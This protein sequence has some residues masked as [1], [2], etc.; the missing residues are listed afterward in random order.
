M[1]AASGG[2]SILDLCFVASHIYP[3]ASV[4]LGEDL[5]SDHSPIVVHLL[6]RP[7][8]QLFKI[9]RK[10][11]IKPELW[12]DYIQALPPIENHLGDQ[13]EVNT[14]ILSSN[15]TSNILKAAEQTFGMSNGTVHPKFNKPWW[16]DNLLGCCGT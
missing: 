14:N 4:S 12:G 15:L 6:V 1:D 5:G 16:L 7:A 10:W 3:S 11:K 9:R 2:P 13:G 8:T